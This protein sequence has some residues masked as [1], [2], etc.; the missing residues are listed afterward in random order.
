ML[1]TRVFSWGKWRVLQV[2]LVTF[3]SLGP[4]DVLEEGMEERYIWLLV[5]EHLMIMVGKLCGAHRA[6]GWGSRATGW[7]WSW[8]WPCKLHPQRPASS[9]W[10]LL[11]NG[12][13]VFCS[14]P[15]REQVFQT[16]ASVKGHRSFK[17]SQ[18]MSIFI[19]S[20][21]LK[22][23]GMVSVFYRAQ[24]C[25]PRLTRLCPSLETISMPSFSRLHIAL[26]VN[27]FCSMTSR[28]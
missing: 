10:T 13:P 17:Q 18:F 27:S 21:K 22:V 14:T 12:S 6:R 7:N 2:E 20:G 28:K 11:P 3:M 9:S 16:W 5:L 19:N 24:K 8:I 25:V 26:P 4:N 1:E 15:A 23:H